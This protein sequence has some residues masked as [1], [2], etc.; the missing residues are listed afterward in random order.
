MENINNILQTCYGKL[1]VFLPP[2]PTPILSGKEMVV[3]SWKAYIAIRTLF[4]KKWCNR[5]TKETLGLTR[6]L[7]LLANTSLISVLGCRRI[8]DCLESYL[9]E[10]SRSSS[11]KSK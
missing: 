9:Y 5:R 2:P 6:N 11:N 10:I 8:F 3:F 4:S 1:L 7:V